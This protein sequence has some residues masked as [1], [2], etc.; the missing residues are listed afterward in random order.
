MQLKQQESQ[1]EAMRKSDILGRRDRVASKSFRI[2]SHHRKLHQ[3]QQINS[4]NIKMNI[5]NGGYVNNMP[6]PIVVVFLIVLFGFKISNNP[7]S[8][9]P[10]LPSLSSNANTNT[11]H[12]LNVV[13]LPS[14][15]WNVNNRLFSDSNQVCRI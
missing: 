6:L 13:K 14:L 12:G 5:R 15:Y 7:V 2:I 8:A 9:L 3:Q 11:N 10:M 1:D 4:N